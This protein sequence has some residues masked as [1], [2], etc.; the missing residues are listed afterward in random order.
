MVAA[1]V[2]TSPGENAYASIPNNT[3]GEWTKDKGLRRLNLGV[4]LMFASAAANGYDGSLMNGLLT[5]PM[6]LTNLGENIDS[7]TLGLI[8]AGISLGG[9]PTFIPASY[10]ADHVGRKKCVALGSVLMIV[11]GIVQA[12]TSGQWAFFGTRIM[13]G[14]GLGFSQTAAPPLITEIAHPRHRGT[15]TAAFQ[16][17]WYWGSILAAAVTLGT[18]YVNNNSSWSWR[19]PCLLQVVFP[20]LQLLGLCIVPESPRWLVSKDRKEE[21]LQILARY[22]A[23]GD[24]SDPLVQFE[25]REI[26]EAIGQ[27]KAMAHK[28]GW[29]EFIETKGARHRL[30]ICILVGFMIQWAGNG[31]VSYYL[32]P[33][34]KTIGITNS[35]EQAGIN[36]GLQVW[37]AMCA[38][39]GAIAAEK[40]GRRPL[41]MVSTMLMLL[42][43]SIV[44]A[45]SAVFVGRGIKAAGGVVV[46]FL[47]L[48]FGSYDI[49]YTPLSIAYPVEILPF[50]LRAKGLSL[51]LTVT[52]A[53]G[54]LNQY[55]NP[56][57]FDAIKWKFYL[58]YVG[59]LIWFLG[60]IYFV[61]PETKG[62]TLEEIAIVFDGAAGEMEA[63]RDLVAVSAAG[64]NP[65]EPLKADV[66]HFV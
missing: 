56:I 66:E 5:L 31:V 21:A 61:F 52:F 58:V 50:H 17:I 49:A 54:F 55:V 7:N 30:V 29:A 48:F 25:F 16:T 65:K 18:L 3:M 45:F 19:A 6:F 44:T 22:H 38:A 34:L 40:H 27:A 20:A 24:T 46:A 26:C 43:L 23:N 37:N 4:C 64:A 41:W 1:G 15:I 60:I 9:T 10:F 8:I 35:S 47:F 63:R 32:A 59:L 36:L 57:A 12:A 42:F 13:M 62:R 14:V 39:G 2:M 53:T 11:A 28:S 51:N 33:I